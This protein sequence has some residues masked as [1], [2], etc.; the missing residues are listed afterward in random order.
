MKRVMKWAG[1]FLVV[2]GTVFLGLI[3]LLPMVLDPNDYKGEISDL[4]YKQSGY[5]L[6]IPGDIVLQ[7]SPRLEVL[8][9]LGGIQVFSTKDISER[10]ILSSEVARVELSLLPLIKERRLVLQGI[11]LHGVYCYLV[12]DMSGKGNWEMSTAVPEQVSSS[13]STTPKKKDLSEATPPVQRPEKAGTIPTLELGA[14]NL[15]RVSL[16]YEDKQSG[17]VFELKNFSLNTGHVLEGQSFH[18]QSQ[19]TLTSSEK[20]KSSLFVE[21]TLGSDI[22]FSLRDKT[23]QLDNILLNNSIGA[24]GVQDAQ[25][26]FQGNSFIDLAQKNISLKELQLSSGYLKLQLNAEITDYSSP[27]FKGNVHIPEFSLAEF[28]KKNRISQP[29]WKSDSALQQV[30]FSCN[31]KGDTKKIDVSAIDFLLDGAHGTGSFVLISPSQPVYDV[32]MHFDR[33]DLDTYATVPPENKAIAKSIEKITTPTTV[34]TSGVA[35]APKAVSLQPLFPVESLR[36]LQFNLDLGVGA[37]KVKGAN[38]TKVVLKA[39]GKNGLLE[40]KPFQTGLYDGSIAAE[41]QLDVVG[42]IPKLSLQA[43]VDHIQVGPLLIDMKGKDE[44]TGTAGLSLQLS[45]KGNLKKQFIRNSQGNMDLALEDGVIRKLHLLQVV[46]Q[47]KALYE[48]KPLVQTAKDEPTGF[49]RISAIGTITNGVF[50]N[51]DLKAESELLKVTG[52]GK[53]D[54]G[55]EYVD[56]LLKISLLRG[57]DRNSE[58][59]KTDYSKIIIPYQ[60]QGEFSNLKQEADVVGLFKAEATSLLMG[61]LQKQL[62]KNNGDTKQ[63]GEKDA[64]INLLEQGLKGLFGN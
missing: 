19:F 46:R 43:T 42:K 37:L 36:K 24:F 25:L 40:L 15:S 34:A 39:S 49:A 16:H 32:T 3:F 56:Y 58:S 20:G 38:L 18:L 30:G 31:F 8:L 28:L 44:V 35:M 61:E 45:S 13:T 62:N 10:P 41:A 23:L 27:S 59:G 17:K 55:A 4:V 33:L 1:A 52:A 51:N 14:V 57:M 29:V 5:Q 64:P 48:N 22:I 26:A 7:I 21:S 2:C 63:D 53:V 12:R 11:Q 6:E 54:F 60:I 9:S 50:K 47:A